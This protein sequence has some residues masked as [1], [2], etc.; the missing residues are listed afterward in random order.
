M[1]TY[2]LPALQIRPPADPLEQYGKV[3]SLKSL[4][5]GQ[6]LGAEELKTR[7]LQNQQT[8]GD[9]ADQQKITQAY[10]Q[11]N[12]NLDQT[13]DLAAKAGVKPQTLL[14]LKA[15][16]TDQQT[17]VAAL[18]KDQ[19]A[20]AKAQ[21]DLVG[22]H[23]AAILAL[24]PE[25]RKD[26]VKQSLSQMVQQGVMPP[27]QAGQQFQQYLDQGDDWLKLHGAAA[28]SANEQ[29]T[30]EF[31]RRED[32]RAAA[33]A[34][35]D[36]QKA[37]ADAAKAG[38]VPGEDVPY[39]P[40]VLAQKKALRAV[41]Q[42]NIFT[43]DDASAVADAIQ[44]GDQPPTVQGLYRNA[45]PVR[46]ELAKRGVPL[47]SMELDWKAVSRHI[48]T[49]NGPQQ[50][51]LRQSISSASDMLD[52]IDGLY[53]EWTQIA[54]TSGYKILNRA[55][56][57]A[58]KNLPG[59]PGAVATALDAQ[60]ADLTADLGN[61]YMGG[62]S[63]TDQSLHLAGK[64]LQTDWNKQTFEEALRQARLNLQI[65]SNSIKHSQ[66]MGVS[67]N[68]PYLPQVNQPAQ[69]QGGPPQGYTR[70]QASDGSVHDIPSA[71]LNAARQRDPRLQ[72]I[73]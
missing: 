23:T 30:A 32:A 19:L 37:Q 5:Q 69:P 26:A 68:S 24:P 35:Y 4:L 60:I 39:S 9:I 7:Q 21:T 59:R 42:N 62:N 52:K 3:L 29:L 66:P 67:P 47:A 58:M 13:V 54:P 6:Q 12:G 50:E 14:K 36:L 18:S 27:D 28:M 11:A 38:K 15:A 63:P 22:Q 43:R 20:N 17:K 1:S 64:N 61:V 8:Q 72:V 45:G 71:N 25:Q 10:I 34:P 2:P 41:N 70:I 33:K 46:A 16:S 44:N 48:Q 55:A 73:Q 56:L 40:E 57:T 53:Q 31:K 51:R 65:R 49:L